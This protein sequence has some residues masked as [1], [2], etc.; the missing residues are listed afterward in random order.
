[1]FCLNFLETL[2]AEFSS[3]FRINGWNAIDNI[4]TESIGVPTNF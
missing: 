3:F 2:S 4:I 1:V